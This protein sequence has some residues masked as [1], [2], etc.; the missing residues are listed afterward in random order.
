MLSYLEVAKA[1]QEMI[2]AAESVRGCAAVVR[3]RARLNGA[4]FPVYIKT[5]SGS[6]LTARCVHSAHTPYAHTASHTEKANTPAPRIWICT[7]RSALVVRGRA[8]CSHP[9]RFANSSS[10]FRRSSRTHRWKNIGY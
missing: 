8:A 6:T 10:R 4:R 5:L 9:R 7:F 2:D 1:E 3:G